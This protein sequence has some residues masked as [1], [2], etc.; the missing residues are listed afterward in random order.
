MPKKKPPTKPTSREH[1]LVGV[2]SKVPLRD[3]TRVYYVSIFLAAFVLLV[4]LYVA[5]VATAIGAPGLGL[6][7][8]LRGLTGK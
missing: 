8:W 7:G 6:M 2:L 3:R 4:G 5:P 1:F